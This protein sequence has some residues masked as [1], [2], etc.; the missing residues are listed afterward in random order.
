MKYTSFMNLDNVH[1][2]NNSLTIDQI[3]TSNF[4]PDTQTSL[5]QASI[6]ERKMLSDNVFLMK[7]S[8]SI[9]LMT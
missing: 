5:A 1:C 7:Q 2:W 4:Y 3:F 6:P 8:Q 9:K